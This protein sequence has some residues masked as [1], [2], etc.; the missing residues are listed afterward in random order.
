MWTACGAADPGGRRSPASTNLDRGADQLGEPIVRRGIRRGAGE[1]DVP[2]TFEDGVLGRRPVIVTD[3]ATG[4][5]N[6]DPAFG[7]MDLYD[8]VVFLV[9]HIS[10]SPPAPDEGQKSLWLFRCTRSLPEEHLTESLDVSRHQP[11]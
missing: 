2:P 6:S 11:E 9:P 8:V 7:Q 10:R 5:T 3:P 4:H 1:L